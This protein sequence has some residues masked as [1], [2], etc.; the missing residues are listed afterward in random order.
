MCHRNIELDLGISKIIQREWNFKKATDQ[1]YSLN[2]EM[3][4][5]YAGFKMV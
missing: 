4:I 1:L 2:R 5:L 3:K